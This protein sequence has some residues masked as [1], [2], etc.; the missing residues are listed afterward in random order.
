MSDGDP[1]NRSASRRAFVALVGTGA[2]AALT[3]ARLPRGPA[4]DVGEETSTR[5]EGRPTPDQDVETEEPIPPSDDS[6]PE[7]PPERDGENILEH[8]AEPNPADPDPASAGRNLEALVA[9]ANAAGEGG[10]IY[11]PAGSYYFGDVGSGNDSYLQFG[12]ELP[13]GISVVGDGPARSSLALTEHVPAEERSNQS[14]FNWVDNHD[15]GTVVVED[16]RLDGN[17]WNLPNLSEAGGGSWGL[18]L[19]GRGEFH[20]SNASI[21]GWYM[22]GIRGRHVLRS[23]T[24]CSFADNGIRRHNDMNGE[25]NS[26]HVTIRPP[27]G[28]E[29]VIEQCAFRDCAGNAV[30]VRY[31]DGTVRVA[32]CYAEGTGSSFCKLSAGG[33]VELTNVYHRANTPSLEEKV[34]ERP[35]GSNFHGRHF[36][37]SLGERGEEPVTLRTNNVVTRDI[38]EYALQSRGTIGSGP[39]TITWEGDMIAIYNVNLN[40]GEEVIRTRSGGSFGSVDLGR[41]SIHNAGGDL[42]SME[43]ATG[44]I[45]T[46]HRGGN[47]GGLGDL[48]GVTVGTDNRGGQ[49]FWEAVPSGSEVGVVPGV[50]GRE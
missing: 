38:T 21:R 35:G 43:S 20:V 36:V 32:G 45:E 12:D 13:A 26:H 9:A 37:N 28:M 6:E 42:F 25:S 16:I 19:N 1:T 17:A 48:D 2:L 4:E 14:A 39:P 11:V 24:R 44:R 33:Y 15:H 27:A 41:L 8:G 40:G 29:C 50:F 3:G 23:V 18:Q 47:G 22:T 34:D 49:P 46:L 7:P 31:D 30:N 5:G 10:T